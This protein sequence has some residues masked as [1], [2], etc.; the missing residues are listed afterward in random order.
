[1]MKSLVAVGACYLD[2]ILTY[3]LPAA[4]LF[5]FFRLT[6][7]LHSV[8]HYPAEDEKL[9]AASVA[10][11]RGGNTLNTLDVLVRLLAHRQSGAASG[12]SGGREGRGSRSSRGSHGRGSAG[13]GRGRQRLF[14]I[15]VLPAR[16]SS[17][18]AQVAASFG[19]GGATVSADHE[20]GEGEDDEDEEDND[21]KGEG[22]GEGKEGEDVGRFV[23]FD[24]DAGG[25]FRSRSVS[26]SRS[27][28]RYSS[29]AAAT[30]AAANAVAGAGA[31]FPAISLAHSIF[32]PE[33]MEPAR[34]WIIRSAHTGSRTIV[35]HS[36]LAEMT[37]EEF[38]L[39]LAKL[40]GGGPGADDGSEDGL[41]RTPWFHFEVCF[42][43]G[44]GLEMLCSRMLRST[45]C[46]QSC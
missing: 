11:R 32:R 31:G 13:R 8:D 28:S 21:D 20:D 7:T 9:R 6:L 5:S 24:V 17:A 30:A 19:P 46:V 1:M 43:L 18:V 40:P 37:V 27:R 45:C 25:C 4:F 34:S 10:I 29:S 33:A 39:A 42:V 14:S 16:D 26:R 3:G 2:T 36:G 23:D 12:G 15:C 35:N 38:A 41:G 44:F 22:K